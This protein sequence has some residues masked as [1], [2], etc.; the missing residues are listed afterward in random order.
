MKNTNTRKCSISGC[1]KGGRLKRGWCGMHYRR[2]QIHGDPLFVKRQMTYS[3]EES[4]AKNT[5]NLNGCI[6]WTGT[7]ADNGYGR[8]FVKGRQVRVHRYVWEKHN[9]QIP[10]GLFI[11]HI[12]H[13]KSCCN[14]K[15]LRLATREQ[16]LAHRAGPAINN[17][18]SGVRNVYAKGDK[19][20]VQVGKN[21]RTHRFGTYDTIEEAAA[22]AEQARLELFGEFAGKG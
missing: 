10:T 4:F 16:N 1:K 21:Y 17:K 3:P 9:G 8:I 2:W 7:K 14:I 18:G 6:I 5:V 13:N 19:W 22:V 15:H 11:D 20:E 12:C